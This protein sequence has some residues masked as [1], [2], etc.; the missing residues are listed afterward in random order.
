[1]IDFLIWGKFLLVLDETASQV[2]NIWIQKRAIAREILNESLCVREA[3]P[4]LDH[5]RNFVDLTLIN[6]KPEKLLPEWSINLDLAKH[7]QD[8]LTVK[9]PL[10][11]ARIRFRLCNSKKGAWLDAPVDNILHLKTRNSEYIEEISREAGA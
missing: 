6:G 10:E 2:Q 7:V 8:F 3:T 11:K 5:D 1:M 9:L 4:N